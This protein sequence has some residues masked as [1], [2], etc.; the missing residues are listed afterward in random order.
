MPQTPDRRPG[1]LL[2]DEEIRLSG[3]AAV[4][5]VD[6]GVT[7]DGT[8][9][10]MRDSVGTF[11]PRT[12]SSGITATE[13]KT[14]RQLIHLAE[15]GGPFEGFASLAYQETLPA[16]NPF[17]TSIIWWTSSA[18]TAKIVEEAVTYNA[19]KTINTDQWKVYDVD[20]TTVLATVTDTMAY[21]G[22]FETS[23]TR[24]IA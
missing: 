7:Y 21:T 12:G 16:A 10:R 14:L 23:R 24:T 18:K 3:G 13:H 6:G 19:N 9:F 22:V 1:P 20:G 8:S 5:S 17:P 2:E 11:N 4:P 15:E